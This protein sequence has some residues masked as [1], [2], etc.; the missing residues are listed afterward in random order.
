[1][2]RD[3]SVSTLLNIHLSLPHPPA[4]T[5]L[6]GHLGSAKQGRRARGAGD[7]GSSAHLVISNNSDLHS[8]APQ[9]VA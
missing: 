8:H 2:S 5:A 9:S 7:V 3:V 4:L 1:M 6:E